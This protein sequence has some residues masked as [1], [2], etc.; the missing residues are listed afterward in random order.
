[1][2][3]ADTR[4]GEPLT[5]REPCRFVARQYTCAA[6]TAAG[7]PI[8]AAP[9]RQPDAAGKSAPKPSYALGNARHVAGREGGRMGAARRTDSVCPEHL[10]G[11]A[12]LVT[13]S[14]P[15]PARS[16]KEDGASVIRFRHHM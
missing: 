3:W 6:R 1:M 16:C 8:A 2:A 4:S 7:S 13:G 9:G 14:P 12:A 15:P 11:A 5:R 10:R